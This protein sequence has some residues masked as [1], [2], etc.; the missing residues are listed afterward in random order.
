MKRLLI[1]MLT[2]IACAGCTSKSPPP[3]SPVDR[4]PRVGF[5]SVEHLETRTSLS[6][7]DFYFQ[8]FPAGV[9]GSS[10]VAIVAPEVRVEDVKREPVNASVEVI[11]SHYGDGLRV[12]WNSGMPDGWYRVVIPTKALPAFINAKAWSQEGDEGAVWF[13]VGSQPIVRSVGRL[14]S[15]PS[16]FFEIHFSEV[17]RAETSK[18]EEL[19]ALFDGDTPLP[20]T[21]VVAQGSSEPVDFTRHFR[22]FSLKCEGAD[23]SASRVVVKRFKT[24]EGVLVANVEGGDPKFEIDWASAVPLE[25]G[26]SEQWFEGRLP[27]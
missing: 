19:V 20:C 1:L 18:L 17:M 5:G 15:G 24:P 25:G 27:R 16:T 13:R 14:R 11:A 7:A 10:V 4:S 8:N 22:S 26:V 6:S 2:F 12:S 3:A 23:L 21:A 9:V